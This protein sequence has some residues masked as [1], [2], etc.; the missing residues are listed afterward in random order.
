MGNRGWKLAA[1][2]MVAAVVASCGGDT[3][4]SSGDETTPTATGGQ[5]SGSGGDDGEAPSGGDDGEAPS[6]GDDGS[7]GAAGM[8]TVGGSGG[9]STGT[10]GGNGG[11]TTGGNGGTEN[12]GGVATGG[13]GGAESTGGAGTGGNGG[14]ENTGGV[15]P[16]GGTGNTG[17]GVAEFLE[18]F[19]T[20]FCTRLQQCCEEEGFATPSLE[21]CQEHELGFTGG[22]LEDGTSFVVPELAEAFRDAIAD[23]CDQPP[24]ESMSVTRGTLDAGAPCEDVGQCAGDTVMCDVTG[25]ADLGICRPLVRGQLGEPCLSTCSGEHCRFSLYRGEGDDNDAIACW[26]D[27]GLYC[28]YS[29]YECVAVTPPGQSCEDYEECGDAAECVGG[30][31]VEHAD[32][33]E[34]CSN[35]G[36]CAS[37]LICDSST[38]TC[39]KMSIAYDSRCEP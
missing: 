36:Y 9:T 38:Y 1:F 20:P 12:T 4:S 39:V 14:T 22:H 5:L 8:S 35:A 24:Y 3:T 30:I 28:S 32:V 19:A 17:G 10:P 27:D 16:T 6:G 29:T 33:G 25:G 2:G 11:V 18:Q 37:T 26:E 34:D 13:N 21:A 15:A 7:S 31:C 23:T